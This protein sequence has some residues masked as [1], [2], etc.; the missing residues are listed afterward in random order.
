MPLFRYFT[1]E[2][3]LQALKN[4]ELIVV[5]PKYLNDPFEFSPIIKCEDAAGF[6]RSRIEE[7]TTSPDFFE[8]NRSHFPVGCTFEQFQAA[9]RQADPEGVQQLERGVS[10][11]DQRI[12]TEAQNIISRSFGVICFSANALNPVMWAHYASSQSGLVVEFNENHLLFS[13][14]SFV[15][16]AYSDEPFIFDASDRGRRDDVELFAKRKSLKWSY[17]QESRL[18][19]E[20]SH[21]PAPRE[22][23]DGRRYFLPID[24]QLITSV[25][26]G[27]RMSDQLKAEVIRSLRTSN[28]EHVDLFQINRNIDEDMLERMPVGR[29]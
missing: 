1:P 26:L 17:E 16:V 14:R 5:P 21:I 29:A 18:V 9:L 23:A 27:L 11:V 15:R 13:G 7:I 20:L 2:R 4:L 3:G 12:Q 10:E 28:L 25:T 19:I 6:T 8:E 24:P 22:T